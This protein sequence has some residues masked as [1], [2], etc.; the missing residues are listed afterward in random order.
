MTQDSVQPAAVVCSVC[1]GDARA[2]ASCRH[3]GGAGVGIPSADGFLVWLKPIDDFFIAF[4]K[5]KRTITVLFHLALI[6]CI[7]SGF[8]F[9]IWHVVQL[10][11]FTQITLREFWLS[12][13][14]YILLFWFS[15]LL[16][17]FF[18]FRLSEYSQESKKL[19]VSLHP[20]SSQD[21]IGR[22][23]V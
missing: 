10:E 5:I 21:Q 11:E 17:C 3:C 9:F 16:G 19:P 12:G 23:H 4:R 1:G 20:I 22:A 14:G 13:Q 2:S 15:V 7:L 18:I 6:V 8:A